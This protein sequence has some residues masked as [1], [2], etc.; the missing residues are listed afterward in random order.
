MTWLFLSAL[1]FTINN[2]LWKKFLHAH[3]SMDLAYKRAIYSSLILL[4]LSFFFPGNLLKESLQPDFYIIL[5]GCLFG[6]AGLFFLIG[7][8]K[9]GNLSL[10][11][12]YN[13][14][15]IGLATLYT[16]LKGDGTLGNTYFAPGMS[17]IILGYIVFVTEGSFS[18]TSMKTKWKDHLWLIGMVVSFTSA[19][20][21]QSIAVTSFSFITIVFSQELV[22]LLLAFLFA[23]FWKTKSNEQEEKI[24]LFSFTPFIMS[25]FIVLAL[26]TGLKGLAITN[27]LISSLFGLLT[28]ILTLFAGKYFFNETIKRFHYLALFIMLSGCAFLY[29]G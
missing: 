6:A 10:L 21:I 12:Y 7:Y 15:G 20:I 27:P 11:G 14:L 24:Q 9:K 1:F 3:L 18:F 13:L 28:P 25:V 29:F 16:F 8:L 17:L 22:V 19:L 4:V 2:I 23:V 26:L 5:V